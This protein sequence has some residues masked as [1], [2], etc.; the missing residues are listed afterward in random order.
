M[1]GFPSFGSGR[2]DRDNGLFDIPEGHEAR[3]RLHRRA[4]DIHEPLG[5]PVS[6]ARRGVAVPLVVRATPSTVSNGRGTATPQPAAERLG[7][8]A[9][10]FGFPTCNNSFGSRIIQ[11]I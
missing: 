5:E 7:A 9:I 4:I 8:L 2:W 6:E 11:Q 3:G 1:P 10:R